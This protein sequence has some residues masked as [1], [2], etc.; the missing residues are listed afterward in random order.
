MKKSV[1]FIYRKKKFGQIEE[2]KDHPEEPEE[3]WV[4][5]I[6]DHNDRHLKVYH[7]QLISRYFDSTNG[8]IRPLAF[9]WIFFLKFH[10]LVGHGNLS[11]TSYLLM[12][13]TFLQKEKH[14]DKATDFTLT[15]RRNELAKVSEDTDQELTKRDEMLTEEM[16]EQKV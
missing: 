16:K 1:T 3:I 8:K 13:V 2:S 11:T 6:F 14:L 7:A 5:V 4:K 15:K 12:L 9:F 10:R